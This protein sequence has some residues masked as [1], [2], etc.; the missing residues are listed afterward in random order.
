MYENPYGSSLEARV[1]SATPLELVQ[2]LFDAA[3]ESAIDARRHLAAGRIPERGRAV[4][5]T[6]AILSEL[7]KSLDHQAGG[8]LSARL[9]ALYDYIGRILL[10]A[11]FRQQDDGL[12]EAETLLRTLRDG[13]SQ[14]RAQQPWTPAAGESAGAHQWSA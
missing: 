2:M 4:S 8:E 9:A 10:E 6:V 3:V 12:A 13:W 14:M 11:N 1:L 5:K 7:S